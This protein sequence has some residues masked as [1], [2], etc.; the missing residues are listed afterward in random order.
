MVQCPYCGS[1]SFVNAGTIKQPK[2]PGETRGHVYQKHRCNNPDCYRHWKGE[3]IIPGIDS[4]IKNP[5][6]GN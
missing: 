4:P 5:V 6:M 2:R 3:E 1:L